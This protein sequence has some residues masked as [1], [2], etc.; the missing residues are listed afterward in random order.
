MESHAKNEPPSNPQFAI[1]RLLSKI[2]PEASTEPLPP[3]LRV[4]EE[5]LRKILVCLLT[6]EVPVELEYMIGCWKTVRKSQH[7]GP[8]DWKKVTV[9]LPGPFVCHLACSPSSLPVQGRE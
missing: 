6:S 8:A 9:K 5:I 3:I 2:P 1:P 7:E 4:P